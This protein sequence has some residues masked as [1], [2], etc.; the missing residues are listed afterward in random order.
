MGSV[1]SWLALRES[2]SSPELKDHCSEQLLI[3]FSLLDVGVSLSMHTVV[4]GIKSTVP[5]D[6]HTVAECHPDSKTIQSLL[7]RW[8][9]SELES[10][11]RAVLKLTSI[12]KVVH[13][14]EPISPSSLSLDASEFRA[15]LHLLEGSKQS[16]G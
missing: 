8:N 11:L 13:N 9:R 6:L 15:I 12:C 14:E 10:L 4:P 1:L 5:Q 3:L 16:G 2:T 7:E